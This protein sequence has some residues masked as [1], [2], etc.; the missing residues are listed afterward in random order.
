MVTHE[1]GLDRQETGSL[2]W[3]MARR[4]SIDPFILMDVMGEANA[5][6]AGGEDII[7]MEV[8]QPAAPAPK[9]ARER[10]R[11]AL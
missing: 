5:C 6:A 4:S 1:L 7:H 10:A 9:A 8:G 3:R 2:P 11:E